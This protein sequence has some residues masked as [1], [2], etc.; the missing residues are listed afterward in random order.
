M[1][2]GLFRL[3]DKDTWHNE[4]EREVATDLSN[5]KNMQTNK[6]VT[7]TLC[8]FVPILKNSLITIISRQKGSLNGYLKYTCKFK[9][10]K[11]SWFFFSFLETGCNHFC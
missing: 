2:K 6:K 11:T 7:N 3:S 9:N 1:V 5:L 4:H 8:L 10:T